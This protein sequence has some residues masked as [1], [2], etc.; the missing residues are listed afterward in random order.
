MLLLHGHPEALVPDKKGTATPW[1]R[2]RADRSHLAG[3][4]RG[5]HEPRAPK[6]SHST[7]LMHALLKPLDFPTP[8]FSCWGEH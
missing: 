7:E 3:G 4:E 6:R 8:I 1:A 2:P 5:Q